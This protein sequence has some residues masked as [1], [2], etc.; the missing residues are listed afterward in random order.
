MQRKKFLFLHNTSRQIN[1]PKHFTDNDV[2]NYNMDNVTNSVNKFF[3]SIGGNLAEKKICDPVTSEEL[4]RKKSQLNVPT[5][6]K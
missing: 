2:N 1:Y 5:E 4:Y 6:V 3:V